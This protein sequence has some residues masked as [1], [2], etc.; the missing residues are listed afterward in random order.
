MFFILFTFLFDRVLFSQANSAD[1]V[2]TV[3][4]CTEMKKNCI[5]GQILINK[6]I[7]IEDTTIVKLQ[8]FIT[9]IKGKSIAFTMI[10][11]T[12]IQ[13]REKHLIMSDYTGKYRIVLDS[14]KYTFKFSSFG[15]RDFLIDEIV[16]KYGQI[17]EINI[18][19]G[20]YCCLKTELQKI[21]NKDLETPIKE[22]EKRKV[23]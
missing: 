6:I 7:G 13:T 8:G 18:D 21:Q 9:D 1:G 19:M 2:T 12:N 3:T 10:K 16:F 14:G 22:F 11:F 20:E 15:Y 4:I 17:S 23:K 5:G